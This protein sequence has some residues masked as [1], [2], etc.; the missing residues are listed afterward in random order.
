MTDTK[1][2]VHRNI[3]KNVLYIYIPSFDDIFSVHAV[4]ENGARRILI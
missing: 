4:T 3:R 1:E 2:K